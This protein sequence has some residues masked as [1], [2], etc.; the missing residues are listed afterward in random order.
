M[1]LKKLTLEAFEPFRNKIE[2]DFEK[3][4]IDKGLLLITGDTGAGK[5]SIFD[6]ICFALFSRASGEGRESYS[7]RSQFA[8]LEE[9]TFVE[10]EFYHNGKLYTVR[11]SPEYER[12]SKKGGG[13]TKQLQT[14]EF[15]INGRKITKYNEVTEEIENLI[16]LNYDQFS[17]LVMLPQGE[18]SKFL[19]APSNEKTGIF[20]QIFD[21]GIYNTIMNY[22]KNDARDKENSLKYLKDNIENEREKLREQTESDEYDSLNLEELLEELSKKIEKDSKDLEKL[23][24]QK[25]KLNDE[26]NKKQVIYDKLTE[27]NKKIQDYNDVKVKLEKLIKENKDID[28]ERELANY[29]KIVVAKLNSIIKDLE[30]TKKQ[31]EENSK[32][33]ESAKEE[34][35]EADK[36]FKENEKNFKE[37]DKFTQK[38]EELNSKIAEEEQY[39]EKLNKYKKLNENLDKQQ[40]ECKTL[41]AKHKKENDK[42]DKMRSVYYLNTAYLVASELEDGKPCPVCGSTDHPHIAEK[43]KDEYTK[44][45]IENQEKEERKLNDKVKKLETQIEETTKNINDL[46]LAEKIDQEKEL[47]N[48]KEILKN[49]SNEK[50]K[51][52]KE[53][54]NLQKLKEEIN[55]KLTKSETNIKT[56]EKQ[57]KDN[58]EQQ[59]KLQKDLENAL[60][61]N[62]TTIEEYNSKKMSV[63]DLNKLE[64][65]IAEFDKN[66]T[67]Y[68]ATIRTLEKELKAKK[69]KKLDDK[70]EELNKLTSQYN[71]LDK[72]YYSNHELLVKLTEISENIEN[73][74]NRFEKEN[75]EYIV[76]SNLSNTANASLKG[77]QKI[78]FENY[79]QA[80]YM[81][82]IIIEANK[83]LL[84]MTD[85][86]FELRRKKEAKNIKEKSGLDFSVYDANTGKERDVSTLSGGEKFKASLS[87]ALGLSDVISMYAGGIKTDCLFVD[88]GFGSL[89]PESLNQA[90][91]I[92]TDLVDTDKL[93]GIISHVEELESRID[94]KIRVQ[95]TKDGSKIKIEA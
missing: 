69:Q 48:A 24:K 93:V 83:R 44:E 45:D 31:I 34:K 14:A 29:N 28:K 77:A 9:P 38:L 84:K 73:Y 79:V 82:N 60:T 78:T 30:N 37:L 12:T 74:K 47:K 50:E 19:T 75:K 81:E 54:E 52:K 42:L 58:E 7:L 95:K 72:E 10:L 71:G 8:G 88:E 49:T 80:I 86:R 46:A 36:Q 40:K 27:L 22:L 16:G 2:I 33:L 90:I 15:E 4:G 3:E 43:T 23:Q 53:N 68:E 62:S 89:D 59:S 25:E 18:F 94:K 32:K 5:T 51:L 26:K 92:L 39:I 6:A 1:R 66:K 57:K 56:F 55:K 65:K 61:E 41:I 70:K 87:L 67:S 20:R 85:G 63:K 35:K 21:T 11:R 13:T 91:N 64:S 17:K 76:V